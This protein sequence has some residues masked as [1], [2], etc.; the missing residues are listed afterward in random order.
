MIIDDNTIINYFWKKQ[1]SY[2]LLNDLN[3][4]I[5]N[6][7]INRYDDSSSI[8]ETINRIKLNIDIVPKCPICG[9]PLKYKNKIHLHISPYESTCGSKKCLNKIRDIHS[10]Q[11]KLERYGDQNYVNKEKAEQTKL[12]RYGDPYY[13]NKEKAEQTNLA[14][15]GVKNV[16]QNK[17][18]INKIEQTKLERYGDP[19]YAN[20][21][22]AEQTKLERYGDPHY[23][24]KE[25]AEQTK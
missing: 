24:N 1:F 16:S 7:L 13:V 23:V 12:E 25:K 4:D 3:E 17:I 11:S 9:N 5:Y 6:Y 2:K 18:I 19:H 20:K 10:K 15:Y 21:E 22:K 8:L 14:K